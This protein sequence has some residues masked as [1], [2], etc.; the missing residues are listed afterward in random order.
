MTLID[1]N[2]GFFSGLWLVKSKIILHSAG[3]NLWGTVGF[4]NL[5]Q[6]NITV[7]QYNTIMYSNEKTLKFDLI[8]I[9]Q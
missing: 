1:A 7:E 9:K 5:M 3:D 8:C 6:R 4:V 2:E